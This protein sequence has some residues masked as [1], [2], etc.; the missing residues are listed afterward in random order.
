[1][2][3]A[4][5]ASSSAPTPGTSP[6]ARSIHPASSTSRLGLSAD[7]GIDNLDDIAEMVRLCNAYG[8]DTIET[9]TALAVAM[10]AGVIPFGTARK[11]LSW[12]MKWQR[13][14]MAEFWRWYSVHR[15][16]LWPASRAHGEGAEHA[17]L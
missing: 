9:G 4:L 14:P 1:M 7:C 15:Q 12:S 10:E 13:K 17:R 6:M 8:L 3:A 16:G 5:D 11:R 2:P